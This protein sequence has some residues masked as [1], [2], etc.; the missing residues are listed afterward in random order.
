MNLP[1][2]VQQGYTFIEQSL[3]TNNINEQQK[4]RINAINVLEK[5]ISTIDYIEYLLIDATPEIPVDMYL[6]VNFNIGTL[7]KTLAETEINNNINE[8]KKN[9]GNRTTKSIYLTSHQE[10]LFNKSISYFTNILRVKIE[11]TNAN[12]QIVSIYTQLT[13]MSQHNKNKCLELLQKALLYAPSDPIIHYNLGH[14]YRIMNKLELGLIHYKLSIKLTDDI[15]DFEWNRKI[16]FNFLN[17]TFTDYKFLDFSD[18]ISNLKNFQQEIKKH[19]NVVLYIYTDNIITFFHDTNTLK[20]YKSNIT[21]D[22][23]LINNLQKLLDISFY[24]TSE[25]AKQLVN[26]YNGISAIFRAIKQWPEALYYSHIAEKI[27]P[28]DPDIQNQL[29]VIY[30]EMR[31]T[32]LAEIAYKKAIENYTKTFVSTDP[33]FLHSELYLNMGHMYSYNGDNDSSLDCYNKSLTICPKFNLPFQNKIMNLCYV[34]DKLLDPMDIYKQHILVN[35]LYKKDNLYKKESLNL[36]KNKTTQIKNRK[37][38]I[39]IISGDFADHP[40]SFF[41]STFLKKYDTTK[42]NITCYS[43]CIIN[44]SILNKFINFKLIKGF[45][46]EDG[47]KMIMNDNIDILLDLAGHT[48]LN[49]LDIFALKPAS[50]QITYIGYP[51]STG[52]YEMDYRITDSFCDNKDISQPFYT[53]KL[54]FIKDCF[55]CYDPEGIRREHSDP[56]YKWTMPQ[57]ILEQPFIKNK[58]LTIGCFNRLNKITDTVINVFNDILLQNINVRFVFKTK[59]LL[60]LKIKENFL[61][62]FDKSVHSRINIIDCTISHDSHLLTYND[63]DI[64][65]DTFPYSGTTTSCESLLMGCPVLSLYDTKFYFHPMNVSVSILKNSGLDFYVCDTTQEIIDKITIIEQK[66]IEF[67][68]SLKQDIRQQFLNGNVCNKN[69]YIENLQTLLL[70]CVNNS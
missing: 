39:G 18:N 52:L 9:E 44:T 29:G 66:P 59:A 63:I 64:A 36:S 8:L 13:F 24:Y 65:I 2:S 31:R 23:D 3:K 35:K 42:F 55:L 32:D 43:E 54:L 30:T 69:K 56:N 14:I 70:N 68:K 51:Y 15:S 62:K 53:E 22:E 17:N 41:V 7:Y 58:Y 26:N 27:L 34:F 20:L 4:L 11:D 5:W 10:S 40:V 60:N 1:V 33:I 38:N 57:L 19:K 28:E 45:S 37:I 16:I 25:K 48:A 12:K 46:A 47:A 6:D 61:S 50:V 67:W 49:R 21:K